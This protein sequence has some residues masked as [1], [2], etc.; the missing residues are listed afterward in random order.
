VTVD[1]E[2]SEAL[3]RVTEQLRP[4]VE[5]AEGQRKLLEERGWSPTAAESYALELLLGMTRL[6]M[7]AKS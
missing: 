3:I 6:V 1:P 4:I 7:G 2:V 5:M